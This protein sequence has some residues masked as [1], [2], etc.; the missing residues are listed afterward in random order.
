MHQ[1]LSQWTVDQ[2]LA[3]SYDPDRLHRAST[4]DRS[5]PGHT[6]PGIRSRA[7]GT[8]GR[9]G[10]GIASWVRR[11]AL[12]PVAEACATDRVAQWR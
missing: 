2:E 12:G 1:L 6:R 4:W 11:G 3:R 9:I 10:G 5:T 7:A 8:V